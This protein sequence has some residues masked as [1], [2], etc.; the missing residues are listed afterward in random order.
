MKVWFKR[1]LVSVVLVVIV[2]LIGLAIFL[3]TFDPNS[4]KSKV[5]EI[6]YNR[7]QRTLAIK[8]DIELSLFPRIGLSVQGVSLSDR[9]STDTFAS[10]DSARFAVAIWP[11]LSNRLVVDHV[12]VSGF[13]AWVIRDKNGEFNFQNLLENGTDSV[14]AASADTTTVSAQKVSQDNNG[15]NAQSRRLPAVLA[16]SQTERT[17]F[18]IDIAGLELKNGEIHAYDAISS[19]VGHIVNL[20]A[21]T[22]RITVNQPFDVAL[23]GKLIGELPIADANIAGNALVKFNPEQGEYSAQKL[24]LQVTGAVGALQAKTASLQGNLAYNAFSKLLDVSNFELLVQGAVGGASPIKNLDTSLS[25]PR[26]KID[27]SRSELNIEKL[28]FRAK[29]AWPTQTFDVAFDAPSLVVSPDTAKGDAVSGTVKLAGDKVLGLALGLKGLGGNAEHLTLK[30]LKV[31]G[32]LK[33]GDRVVQVNLTSPAEWNLLKDQGALSAL[34]G[35]VKIEGADLPHGAFEFPLIGNVHADLVKDEL[36]S[37]ISAIINGSTVAFDLKANQLADPR[38]V[39]DLHADAIDFNNFLSPPAKPAPAAGAG[40][41]PDAAKP[42][43]AAP[44]QPETPTA[45]SQAKP[46]ASIDLALLDSLNLSGKVSLGDVKAGGIEAKNFTMAVRSVKGLLTLSDIAA[47]L[48]Q[49]KLSGKLTA[50]SKNAFT[51]QLGLDGVLVGA[52]LHGLT[53]EARLKG[54]GALK[55][56]LDS[57]GTTAAALTAGLNG[58]VQAKV[59]DGAIKGINLT[60]TLREAASVVENVFSGQIPEMGTQFDLGRQTEFSS[61]DADI[62]FALGQ[63]TVKKLNVNAPLLRVSVGSP[64]SVDLVNKQ[65]DVVAN[66]RVVNAIKGEAGNGLAALQGVTVPVRVSGPFAAPGYQV[67][68]KEIGSRAVKQAVEG[69]LLDLISNKLGEKVAPGSVKEPSPAIPKKPT[70]TVKSI[71]NALKGLL[72]Q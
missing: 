20:K 12:A 60:Q 61:M 22:G 54:T 28:S 70:D 49:G 56:A 18:Q 65:L 27:R 16:A 35:D 68:W 29:G 7:Y 11:L 21:N 30:E 34:K 52:L 47:D 62:T 58:T 17:D 72:G 46:P 25:A 44:A 51:A 14:A 4:Y 5:E 36:S 26:L 31:D 10:I 63:G 64:A 2:A 3:L 1:I 55:L 8:G 13:K 48:Y 39:F 15:G 33:Q 40:A 38:I 37:Q 59:H 23:S 42:V 69:G 50:S 6:V 57:Q 24:N 32:S 71:G 41:K 19:Y 45:P 67:Q 9:N 66:V 43:A 53:G